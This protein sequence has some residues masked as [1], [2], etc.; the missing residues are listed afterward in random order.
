[1]Q[2]LA[3]SQL[4]RLNRPIGSLLLLWPTLTALWI[5]S[6]GFPGLELLAIFTLGTFIMRSA[7]CVINDFADRNFDGKVSRTKERPLVT[8]AVKSKEALTLF[9]CL[10]AC[11]GGLILLLN[12]LTQLLAL[13][14]IFVI[15]LYPFC[16][17][18]TYLPQLIL[19]VAFSWGNPMAWAA[20]SGKLTTTAAIFFCTC[21]VWIVAYDTLYAVVD[22][23]DDIKVGIKSSALLFG[24]W[25]NQIVGALQLTTLGGFF[26]LG[27]ELGFQNFFYLGLLGCATSFAFQQ[28]LIFKGKEKDYFRAF[29]NNNWAGLSLFI[30]T[31]LETQK[32]TIF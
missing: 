17:R 9:I 31:A 2:L 8:G 14:A 32:W 7:G 3:Y 20:S 28:K 23:K 12:Q 16:K 18:W 29:L 25:T 26:F 22:K 5:A 30:G 4:M 1:M 6:E 27:L 21:L 19:G 11:G 15:V 10:C 24:D 13:F